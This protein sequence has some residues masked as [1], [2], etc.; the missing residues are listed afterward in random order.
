MKTIL[1]C[2]SVAILLSS[3]A[4]QGQPGWSHG[5]SGIDKGV[6]GG[7]AG[8]AGGAA[9]GSN[10]GKGRGNIAAIAIGTLLGAGLGS[11]VGKSLD[12]ADMGYYNQTSQQALNTGQP[13]QSF[14]WQNPQSGHSGSITPSNYYPSNGTYCRE[15][16]QTVNIGGQISNGYG[17]ACRQPDGRWQVVSN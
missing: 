6:L 11:E 5:G 8:A 12:R 3:C 7:L 4:Q 2:M 15:Y 10:I 1:T 14:P 13:G 17:T 16:T 9:I